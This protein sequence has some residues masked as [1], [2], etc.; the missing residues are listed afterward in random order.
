MLSFTIKKGLDV[1]LSGNPATRVESIN[2]NSVALVGPDYFALKPS[3]LVEIGQSVKVGEPLFH[4]KKYPEIVFTSPAAGIVKKVNRGLKRVF[5]SVVIEVADS[6][7][8]VDFGVHSESE[9]NDLSLEDIQK[10][11]LKSG[12][13][14]SLRTR[15]FGR[16]PEPGSLAD[17]IFITAIDTDPTPIRLHLALENKS[18]L[19]QAGIIVLSKL[20][21]GKI[22]FCQDPELDITLPNINNVERAIFDGV[23]PAGLP[24]THINYIAPASKEKVAWYLDVQDV[25][26]IGHLFLKGKL[27]VDRLV[28]LGGPEVKDPIHINTRIGASLFDLLK[29]R[30]SLDKN[31]VIS[32]SVLA[33]RNAVEDE[34][35]AFLYLGRYHKR[36]VV[37]QEGLERFFMGWLSPGISKFSF[38]RIYLSSIFGIKNVD[39]TTSTNGSC[40]AIVPL[41]SYEEVI[42]L[43]VLATPLLRAI[44]IGDVEA[45]E[46]LGVLE[47]E[48]ADLALC[49]F[50]CHS[51]HEYGYMLRSMLL[52][53]YSEGEAE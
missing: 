23:H 8:Y 17:N 16:V 33:G 44:C 1:P 52:E 48:E 12:Q 40:R 10:K 39:M 14:T 4:D 31:R 41:D 53:I 29:G 26:A 24:G 46:S 25:I 20:T 38:L 7:E 11:L 49:T 27:M 6:E 43:D 36:V 15:P 37:L 13:W 35:G 32:G 34:Q 19:L 50:I 47:L 5:Q 22:F 21:K 45:A 3:F 30:A 2:V 28:A 42:P 9:I 18:D 51:K